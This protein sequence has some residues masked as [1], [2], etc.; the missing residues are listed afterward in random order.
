MPAEGGL[1][2]FAFCLW[3]FALGFFVYEAFGR[4]KNC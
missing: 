1:E 2:A 4:E 3:L